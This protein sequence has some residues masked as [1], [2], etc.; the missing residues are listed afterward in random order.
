MDALRPE[1]L[2]TARLSEALAG[3][4]ERWSALHGIPVQVTTTGT[5]RPMRPETEVALL[6]DR[7]RRRWPTSPSTRR[8]PGSA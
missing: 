4:A 3:V 1:P 8:R 5:T 2:E 7:R 6:R